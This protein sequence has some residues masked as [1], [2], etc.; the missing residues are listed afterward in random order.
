MLSVAKLN[1]QKNGKENRHAF[2]DVGAAAASMAIQAAAMDLYLHQM[3]G[4]DVPKAQELYGIPEGYE[5][6]AAI[7]LGYRGDTHMLPEELQ[8]RELA[9]RSR[10]SLKDRIVFLR[11]LGKLAAGLA[12]AISS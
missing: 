12:I 6:V 7:A 2:D 9:P 3:A 4:F 5:P 8:Q 10:K 11:V 1:F